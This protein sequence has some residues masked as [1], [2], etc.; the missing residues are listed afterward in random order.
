MGCWRER[1]LQI[2][3]RNHLG[4]LFVFFFFLNVFFVCYFILFVFVIFLDVFL[5]FVGFLSKSKTT[6][7][8]SG[9]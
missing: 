8:V 7:E 9:F 4:S 1:G 3:K 2:G 6:R 5:L